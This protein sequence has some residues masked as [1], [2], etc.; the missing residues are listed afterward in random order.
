MTVHSRFILWL[1][2]ATDTTHATDT[3]GPRTLCGRAVEGERW[4]RQH[5]RDVDE[6]TVTCRRCRQAIAGV[7][8]SAM[9]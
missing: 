1:N 6:S 8:R 7:E 3:Y 9:L 5:V 4:V 2:T